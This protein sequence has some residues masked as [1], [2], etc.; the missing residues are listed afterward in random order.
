[1]RYNIPSQS[2]IT[3]II[4]IVIVTI[5]IIILITYLTIATIAT[6][7]NS[8]LACEGQAAMGPTVHHHH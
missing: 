7:T 4:N 2:V 5:I 6:I 8:S 1:M 3:I